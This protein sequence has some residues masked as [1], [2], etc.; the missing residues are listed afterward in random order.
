MT[1]FPPKMVMTKI[2]ASFPDG[3][4]ARDEL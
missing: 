2:S 3:M 4:D 1:T